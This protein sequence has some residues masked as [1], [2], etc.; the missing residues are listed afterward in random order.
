MENDICKN[1][2][3][4]IGR[5]EQAYVYGGYVVC[6]QCNDSLRH[7]RQITPTTTVGISMLTCA[8]MG[9]ICGFLLIHFGCGQHTFE[10]LHFFMFTFMG[11]AFVGIFGAL[12]G[13][14]VGLI[15]RMLR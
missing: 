9:F 8:V 4:P 15:V 14:G 3:R 6:K 2:G 5:L 1:C 12:I 11:A 13:I 7:P 10:E